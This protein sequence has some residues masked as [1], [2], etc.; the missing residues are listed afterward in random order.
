LRRAIDGEL[1]PRLRRD[2]DGDGFIFDGTWR[3][4]PDPS[5]AI[6]SPVGRS[7]RSQQRAVEMQIFPPGNPVVD[8]LPDFFGAVQAYNDYREDIIGDF[9]RLPAWVRKIHNASRRPENMNNPNYIDAEFEA[10]FRRILHIRVE[11][12]FSTLSALSIEASDGTRRPNNSNRRTFRDIAREI[13]NVVVSVV[14]PNV[15]SKD[16]QANKEKNQTQIFSILGVPVPKTVGE[17]QAILRQFHPDLVTDLSDTEAP[18]IC[19]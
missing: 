10:V 5:R 6:T 18:I 9:T 16:L 11:R 7:F 14:L 19:A 1:D 17:A 3:E 2:S 12:L 4:M 13:S 15:T 8:N